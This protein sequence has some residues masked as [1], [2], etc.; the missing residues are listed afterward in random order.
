MLPKKVPCGR[1]KTSIENWKKNYPYC[2]PSKRITSSTPKTTSQL[3]KA[4]IKRRCSIKRSFPHK[5]LMP[6]VSS[7]RKLHNK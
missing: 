6:D 4:E 3:S 2:R 5:R 7:S 1:P